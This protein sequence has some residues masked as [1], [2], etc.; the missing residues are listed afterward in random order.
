MKQILFGLLILFFAVKAESQENTPKIFN[1]F[2]KLQYIFEQKNDT[3]YVINFWA[4]WCAPCVAELPY[5]E[6]L[7][8]HYKNEKIK[9]ILVSLDFEKQITKKLIPFI[10]KNKIKSEVIVLTDGK[11]NEW[12]GKVNEEWGGAIPVTYFYKGDSY[13]FEDGEF[14]SFDELTSIIDLFVKEDESKTNN[15]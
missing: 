9:V 1:D 11:S 7:T 3:T 13:I 14:E 10:E 5:F 8:D 12:I 6:N 2:D 15:K 4:T